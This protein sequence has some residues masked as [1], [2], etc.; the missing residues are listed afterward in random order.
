MF[1]SWIEG[2]V[3][4]LQSS[5]LSQSVGVLSAVLATFDC[6][7]HIQLEPLNSKCMV[8]VLFHPSGSV[9][10]AYELR[11]GSKVLQLRGHMATINACCWCD[12][13]GTLLTGSN[14]RNLIVWSPKPESS[15]VCELRGSCDCPAQPAEDRDAWSEDEAADPGAG[16]VFSGLRQVGANAPRRAPPARQSVGWRGARGRGLGVQGGVGGTRSHRRADHASARIRRIAARLV[17]ALQPHL[18]QEPDTAG[19]PGA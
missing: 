5:Y 11:T 4:V 14:D 16:A 8:Q 13:Q 3:F 19:T 9:V 7:K 6:S 17:Q 2:D 1:S 10:S 15:V 12:R 18:R